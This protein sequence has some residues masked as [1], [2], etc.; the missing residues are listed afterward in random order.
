MTKYTVY[1]ETMKK[2]TE[3]FSAI[4]E[5]AAED[6]TIFKIEF[7]NQAG[8]QVTWLRGEDG[9]FSEQ[10]STDIDPKG[11]DLHLPTVDE[12][13]DAINKMAAAYK[14]ASNITPLEAAAFKTLEDM[15]PGRFDDEENQA[16]DT[17]VKLS[18]RL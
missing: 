18:K 2:V 6:P 17:V 15:A 11:I 10:G 14:T 5:R 12:A 7:K 3:D 16:I 1:S 8:K 4:M 9:L 13:V